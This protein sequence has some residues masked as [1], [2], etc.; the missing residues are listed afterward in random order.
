MSIKTITQES[1]PHEVLG[2]KE[3]VLV[4]FHA[5]WCVYCRRIAPV[6]ERVAQAYKGRVSTAQIDTDA[7]PALAAR[8]GVETIP[9][10]F[11]FRNG[12]PGQMLVAPASQAA[13]EAWLDAQL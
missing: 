11:L 2:A 1:F 6:L 13:L 7:C 10:L 8:Y 4:E 12:Q 5:P 9:A 3:P